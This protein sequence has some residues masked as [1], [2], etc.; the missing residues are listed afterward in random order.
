[1]GFGID[2]KIIGSLRIRKYNAGKAEKCS[3]NEVDV[4]EL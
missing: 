4:T 1:V 3:K 2:S